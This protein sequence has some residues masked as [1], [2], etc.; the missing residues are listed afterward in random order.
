MA[1]VSSYKGL[2]EWAPNHGHT[3][4]YREVAKTTRRVTPRDLHC[5]SAD[6]LAGLT[7]WVEATLT[8]RMAD[9]PWILRD[10]YDLAADIQHLRL[11]PGAWIAKFD[12]KHFYM[13]G[14][15]EEIANT[16]APV[17]C[18]TAEDLALRHAILFLLSNQY[19]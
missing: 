3:Q 14:T 5:L 12:I 19:V 17:P 6:R 16:I 18:A 8:K 1:L 15:P 2:V 9:M 13:S 7:K 10:S 11:P 4:H